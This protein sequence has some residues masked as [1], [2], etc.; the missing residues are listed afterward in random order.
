LCGYAEDYISCVN[1]R[2]VD[3]AMLTR[4]NNMIFDKKDLSKE[5]VVGLYEL[6]A[7]DP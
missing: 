6:N 1:T 3:P 4:I 7:A 2:E 5:I